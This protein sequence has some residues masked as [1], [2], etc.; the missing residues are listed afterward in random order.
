MEQHIQSEVTKTLKSSE[1]FA[2]SE[3]SQR[4]DYYQ[5]IL[6]W[7]DS[8]NDEELTEELRDFQKKPRTYNL[9]KKKAANI[10]LLNNNANRMNFSV[11][12]K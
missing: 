4:E 9:N 3:Y 11:S 5:R 1:S 2:K 6:E 7:S 10:F 8:D 12:L